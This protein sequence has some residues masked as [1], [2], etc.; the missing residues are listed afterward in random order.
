VR[1][2]DVAPWFLM[3]FGFG[4][5]TLALVLGR[6]GKIRRDE[7]PLYY[8]TLAL[9]VWGGTGLVGFLMLTGL[10]WLMLGFP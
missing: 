10:L 2:V 1:W 9:L 8:W 7:F 6:A 3:V 5:M 4:Q